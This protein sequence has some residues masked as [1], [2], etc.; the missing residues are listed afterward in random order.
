MGVCKFE[1][2]FRHVLEKHAWDIWLSSELKFV[3]SRAVSSNKAKDKM[4]I[5]AEFKGM[6]EMLSFMDYL[7]ITH[8]FFYLCIWKENI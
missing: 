1:I 5:Y 4:K 6:S 2:F 3:T 7:N 8:I